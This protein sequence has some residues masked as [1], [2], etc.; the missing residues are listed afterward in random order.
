MAAG[1]LRRGWFWLLKNTVNRLA[2]RAVHRGWGPLSLVRHT[3]R[4]TGGRYETPLLLVRAGG[5]FVAE[6]TYGPGVA[7][8]RNVLAAGGC[9]VL[10]RGAAYEI[11]RVEPLDPAAGRRAFGPVLGL[12]LRLTARRDYRLLHV[13]RAE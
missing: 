1:R 12:I 3:G 5:D 13:A 2:V 4:R 7:W 11:D 9:S 6:L 8:H 10:H